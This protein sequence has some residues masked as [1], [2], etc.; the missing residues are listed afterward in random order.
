MTLDSAIAR[1]LGYA[2]AAGWLLGL[3]GL[4]CTLRVDAAPPALMLASVYREPLQPA[5]YLVSEKLDGVRGRWDGRQLTTRSGLPIITPPW[6][7]AGWP[8]TALDGELW[9][10]RGQFEAVSALVRSAN[11]PAEPWRA[12]RFMLFDVPAHPGRFAER[13][14]AMRALVARSGNPHLHMIE[15]HR[16]GD[17]AE[18]EARLQRVL[19]AGGEG[20]MLHHAQARYRPG[21]SDALLKLKPFEDAEG[22]VCGYRPGRGKYRGLTGA[23]VLELDDGRQLRL[24][25]GL[26]DA[27]RANPPPLGSRVTFRYSGL[28]STGLPRFARYLRVRHD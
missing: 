27:E 12:V 7:T 3:I 19:A 8:D 11:R 9:I 10:G 24:G 5:A 22:T 13:V 1:P 16:V 25:S 15:Q 4:L 20:L 26:S 18:L 23:L 17:A 6:F 14:E 21:R 28:T 2:R